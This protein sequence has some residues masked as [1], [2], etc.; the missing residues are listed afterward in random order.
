MCARGFTLVELITSLLIVG[1]LGAIAVPRFFETP[2]YAAR[3][4]ADEVTDALRYSQLIA[5]SS[6]CSVRF[7]V[8]V[9]GGYSSVQRSAAGESCNPAGAWNSNVLRPDGTPLAGARPADVPPT[10]ATIVE[11]DGDGRL[12]GPAQN[13][14]IG[15]FTITIDGVSGTVRTVP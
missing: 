15:T 13:I 9:A 8:G 14:A 4:F 6:R 1:L 7:V 5:R 10:A 11:F 12:V 3:G 2:P